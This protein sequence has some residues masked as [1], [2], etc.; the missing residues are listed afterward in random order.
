MATTYRKEGVLEGIASWASIRTPNT[1]F[2]EH[3]YTI[4][5]AISPKEAEDFASR[6]IKIKTKDSKGNDLEGPTIVIKRNVTNRA[7]GTAND[8]PILIDE[9]KQPTD[10]KVGNGSKVQV[11][12]EEIKGVGDKTKNPYHILDLKAVMILNLVELEATSQADG[13]VFFEDGDF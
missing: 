7:D 1:N 6:G 9:K 8:I 4:D 11:H 2:Q 5:L 12:Y 10:V 3:Y 13:S